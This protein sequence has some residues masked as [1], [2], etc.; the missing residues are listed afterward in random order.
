LLPF[1]YGCYKTQFL[2]DSVA[3]NYTLALLQ[4]IFTRR[5]P[6]TDLILP[7]D[8]IWLLFLMCFTCMI[9]E[10]HGYQFTVLFLSRYTT[11]HAY[12][13]QMH[14][15]GHG[16]QYR[17][18]PDSLRG[19]QPAAM[20]RLPCFCCAPGCRS[21]VDH[22]RARPLKDFRT[23]Q[24][25][26]RRRHCARPF[27]CRRC[28]KA[29]A[30]RGDWRTHEKNCGRRWRCACGSDFKH[31]RSL[32]D[33]VRAFGRDHVEERTPASSIGCNRGVAGEDRPG[34]GDQM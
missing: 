3:S 12:A 19:A 16:S 24:T 28:G 10:N 33:H 21:H 13:V 6:S 22:P 8:L 34:A 26:Y 11:T 18:G 9:F 32:R 14:M 4:Q 1:Y 2:S 7:L 25:H 5:L 29:L 20:L 31:K 30:V 23:L 27:L 17:R 15:W